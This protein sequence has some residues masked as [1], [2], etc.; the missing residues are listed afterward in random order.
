MDENNLNALIERYE[1]FKARGL[2]LDMS[3]GKPEARQLDLSL[4]MLEPMDSF[5]CEDGVDARNYGDPTGIP[6]AKRLF[7]AL[8]GVPV[9]PVGGSGDELLSAML[10]QDM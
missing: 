6:E 7:G 8:L 1:A 2:R 4:P 10:G 5:V 9:V 3:R